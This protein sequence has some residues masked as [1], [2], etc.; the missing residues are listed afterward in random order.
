[1]PLFAVEIIRLRPETAS[2]EIEAENLE[3]LREAIRDLADD[4]PGWSPGVEATLKYATA[5]DADGKNLR[6][7]TF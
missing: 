2:V 7:I 1:M 6:L 3:L 4:L 5:T